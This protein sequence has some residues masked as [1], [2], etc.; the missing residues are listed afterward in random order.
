[1]AL[2]VLR[3]KGA[4]HLLRGPIAD[5][6]HSSHGA[7]LIYQS[8]PRGANGLPTTHSK[9]LPGQNLWADARSS[10]KEDMGTSFA[11]SPP[12]GWL[13]AQGRRTTRA[14]ADHREALLRAI[15]PDQ[16]AGC[17]GTQD[18][19]ASGA[20]GFWDVAG[21]LAGVGPGQSCEGEGFLGSGVDPERI[22]R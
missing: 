18:A 1:M 14:H 16:Q 6:P 8:S 11:P 5:T 21:E 4:C 9:P 10:V 17:V 13:A 20:G 22:A 15:A 12:I 2:R 7:N 19:R 3:T